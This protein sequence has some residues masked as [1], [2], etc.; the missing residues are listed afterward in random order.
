[1]PLSERQSNFNLFYCGKIDG[2]V[3]VSFNSYQECVDW[4]EQRRSIDP[5]GVDR[6]DYFIDAPEGMV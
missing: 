1:M 5:D 2:S 3:S 4:I 6:G